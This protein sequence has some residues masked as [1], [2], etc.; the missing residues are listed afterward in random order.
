[1]FALNGT[2]PQESFSDQFPD[3]DE[4]M[5]LVRAVESN[6][7]VPLKTAM[8]FVTALCLFALSVPVMLLCAVLVR[9]TSRGPAFY[10]QVRLGLYGRPYRIYKLRTMYH[11]C[12][13]RTGPQWCRTGDPRI[14]PLGRFLRRTHLDELPQLFNVLRGDMALIG[15]RP[16]RPEFVPSLEEA[17]PLYRGRLLLRPGGTGLAQVQLPP[18]TDLESVRRK[19]AYDLCYVRH[20]SLW[21]DLRLLAG[22]ALKVFGASFPFLR[23]AFL[24]PTEKMVERNYRELLVN[25]GAPVPSVHPQFATTP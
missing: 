25:R 13:A 10:S 12:E 3:T 18:D 5:D 16:E 6:W 7:Y 17:L 8:E 21:L 20:A 11:D 24:L 1:M 22:T 14:T 4:G 15:P 23:T 19:L 2:R 9:L